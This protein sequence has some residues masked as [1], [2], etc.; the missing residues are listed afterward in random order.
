MVGDMSLFTCYLY[1]LCNM[2]GDMSLY[3]CYLCTYLLLLYV[4]STMV[5][6]VM[7]LLVTSMI[8]VQTSTCQPSPV[9][10]SSRGSGGHFAARERSSQ[11]LRTP[12]IMRSSP[13]LKISRASPGISLCGGLETRQCSSGYNSPSSS[14][15]R[16]SPPPVQK[17]VPTAKVK[18]TILIVTSITAVHYYLPSVELRGRER[19]NF[20]C[21]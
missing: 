9:K 2:V 19:A 7:C 17:K 6:G 12:V 8:L 1:V 4:L 21:H 15:P 10:M 5:E 18:Y 14:S 16:E 3:T 20:V 13:V 11:S